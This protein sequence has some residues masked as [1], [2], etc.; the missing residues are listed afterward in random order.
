MKK[1]MGIE[2]KV[3]FFIILGILA[4][5][6]YL[7]SVGKFGEMG[8]YEIKVEFNYV[9]G[10]DIGSPV[11]V[12]G[13]RVGEVK[14]IKV[15]YGVKPTVIVTLKLKPEVK[16]GK[17]SRITIRSLGIIGEKYVEIYPSVEE[18]EIILP[19]EIV[20]G[21]D[22]LPL[23]RFVNMGEDI[24]RNLNAVLLSIRKIVGGKDIQRNIKEILENS[25]NAIVKAT[26]FLKRVNSLSDSIEN[27]N[28]EIRETIIAIRPEIKKLTGK[29]LSFISEGEKTFSML[30][31]EIEKIK[32]PAY[33]TVIETKKFV[34]RLQK[35]GLIARLMEEK[36][37][38]DDLKEQISLLKETTEKVRNSAERFNMLCSNINDVVM[39]LKESQ[40]TL[41][42]LLMSDEIYNEVVDFIKDIKQHPWKLFIKR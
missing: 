28:K 2:F 34:E 35:E 20:R 15:L 39:K 1:G 26:D 5:L 18:K 19:G 22:P 30:N 12:S 21:I 32:T 10:L 31:E 24:I 27:T 7:F 41:W 17:H 37:L 13:V 25:N 33:E 40:G 14:D 42:K 23:E 36:E 6:L 8:G 4:L 16:I 29:S 9:G 3:G 11:R 38:V